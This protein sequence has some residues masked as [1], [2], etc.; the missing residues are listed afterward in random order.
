MGPME[1]FFVKGFLRAWCFLP[2][3]ANLTMGQ[4]KM[5]PKR[6]PQVLV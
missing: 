6:G 4:K 2:G 3:F 5:P 1:G